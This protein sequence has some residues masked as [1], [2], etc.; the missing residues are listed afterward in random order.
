MNPDQIVINSIAQAHGGKIMDE[1]YSER[2]QQRKALVDE[3]SALQAKREKEAIAH[4]QN[5][6]C[7][8]SELEAARRRV[9]ELEIQKAK[10]ESSRWSNSLEYE[11][12]INGNRIALERM[13]L[14]QE[15]DAITEFVRELDQQVYRKM[16]S[17]TL[18]TAGNQIGSNVERINAQI[19]AIRKAA[20]KARN[21]V[22]SQDLDIG[23][24]LETI[25]AE[26]DKELSGAP[27]PKWYARF[28]FN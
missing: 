3:I 17:D 21:L 24:Q 27:A 2:R 15:K 16:N 6:E 25:E 8:E 20:D 13:L 5:C 22:Y 4:N 18:L 28:K 1:Y 14:D 26:L 7:V 10:A 19:A 9:K 11:R 12:L 23:A